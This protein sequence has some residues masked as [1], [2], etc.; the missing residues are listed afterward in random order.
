[1]RSLSLKRRH[2]SIPLRSPPV[3]A[4]SPEVHADR[5]ITFRVAAPGAKDVSLS[6]DEGKVQTHAMTRDG[7]G[8][9]SVTSCR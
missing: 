6:F 1:M 4:R 5:R 7:A 2:L 8:L 3:H 9:W